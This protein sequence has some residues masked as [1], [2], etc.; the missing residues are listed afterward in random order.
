MLNGW[1]TKAFDPPQTVNEIYSIA[2]TWVRPAPRPDGGTAS[3]YVTIVEEAKNKGKLTKKVKE[4]KK[5]QAQQLA[6]AM[7]TAGEPAGSGKEVTKM[8]KD[9]SHIKCFRCNEYGHYSTSKDCPS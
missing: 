8:P 5:K 3:S 4:E 2:G 6:V 1:A 7:A 9:L